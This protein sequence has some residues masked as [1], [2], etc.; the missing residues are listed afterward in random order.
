MGGK[1]ATR[2][3]QGT[4]SHVLGG[5]TFTSLRTQVYPLTIEVLCTNVE[6]G[7]PNDEENVGSQVK[8]SDDTRTVRSNGPGTVTGGID[9]HKRAFRNSATGAK[10]KN[11][12]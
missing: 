3:L 1:S 10:S 9:G 8:N 4:R 5:H 12:T 6:K 2:V 11:Y 7:K